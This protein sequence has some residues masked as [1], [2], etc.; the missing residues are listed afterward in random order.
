MFL[1]MSLEA[2]W[3][4]EYI[5]RG[6]FFFELAELQINVVQNY[7]V[8]LQLFVHHVLVESGFVLFLVLVEDRVAACSHVCAALL[9]FV[10]ILSSSKLLF[11]LGCF[12]LPPFKFL[13]ERAVVDLE[14]D[15]T[16]AAPVLFVAIHQAMLVELVA[17]RVHHNVVL[18]FN[19]APSA[20]TADRAYV[21]Q[22]ATVFGSCALLWLD[23]EALPLVTFKVKVK[24]D[25]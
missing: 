11:L 6:H 5:S 8:L 22:S 19:D 2:S 13:L 7:V 15:G 18:V 25:S 14:A 21:C 12:G 10:L 16:L 23:H 3:S 24:T 1:S 20:V 9:I 17:A 4:I